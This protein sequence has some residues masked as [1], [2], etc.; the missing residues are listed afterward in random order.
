MRIQQQVIKRYQL[1]DL[2]EEEYEAIRQGLKMLSKLEPE[3]SEDGS[4]FGPVARAL[5]ARMTQHDQPN[6]SE[7][8]VPD[9][10]IDADILRDSRDV[11]DP[12]SDEDPRPRAPGV[13]PAVMDQ[14]FKRRKR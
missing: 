9:V 14:P 3:D 11:L 8:Y 12:I 6:P 10:D 5:L 4:E 13:T 1:S 2:E 7:P